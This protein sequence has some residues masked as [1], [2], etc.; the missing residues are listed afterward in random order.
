MR[1]I[2]VHLRFYRVQTNSAADIVALMEETA[3][4]GIA[5]WT[6]RE[7]RRIPHEEWL[8]VVQS[9]MQ[10]DMRPLAKWRVS[11]QIRFDELPHVSPYF[12]ISQFDKDTNQF[13]IG[14]LLVE[15]Q[16]HLIEPLMQYL[17]ELGRAFYPIVRP[18]LGY[19]NEAFVNP[20][21][22][23]DVLELRLKHISW[24]NFFSPAYVEKYGQD[25]LQGLPGYKTELL[26]DGGVFH[27]LTPT[28]VAPSEQA[29]QA[30]RRQVI[31]YCAEHGLKVT[32]RAPYYI[33]GAS[34][35]PHPEPPESATDAEV[36][37]FLDQ[38]LA[39]TFVLNDGTRVK[40]IYIPWDELTPRQR[41]M[42]LEAVKEAAI[43][44]IRRPGRKRIRFEFDQIP[45]DLDRMLADLAG[46][47]NPDFEWVEVEMEP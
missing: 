2:Q 17:L 23:K 37:S 14:E 18:M 13:G 28:F 40:P 12:D 45:D 9:W 46:R 32:C 33:S 41:A 11:F 7:D 3:R 26:A 19:V 43:A 4:H 1:Q 27:Q 20:T 38:I 22:S 34:P 36:Q 16:Y 35:V 6:A 39:T 31:T 25:F 30:L 8:T 47:D 29:A 24:V 42:A 21:L 44:E 10:E 15:D 5:F